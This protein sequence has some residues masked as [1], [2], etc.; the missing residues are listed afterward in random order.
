[1][2]ALKTGFL[3][4]EQGENKDMHKKELLFEYETFS[5]RRPKSVE[6]PIHTRKH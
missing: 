2:G 4:L 3:Q 6:Y 5:I 1:L